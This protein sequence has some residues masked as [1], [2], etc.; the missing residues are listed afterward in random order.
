MEELIANNAIF[1]T[2]SPLTIII[3]ESLKKAGI[4]NKYAGLCSLLIGI[5]L[6]SILFISQKGL[7]LDIIDESIF[8]GIL[9]GGAASGIFSQMKNVIK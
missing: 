2:L 4:K 9:L 3:V 1:A 6:S 7:I 5:T 8:T